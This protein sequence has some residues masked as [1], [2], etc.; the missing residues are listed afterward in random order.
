[1]DYPRPIED[2]NHGIFEG[3]RNDGVIGDDSEYQR[4]VPIGG[5]LSF[6]LEL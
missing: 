4:W 5:D 6:C 2:T 3:T 1:M